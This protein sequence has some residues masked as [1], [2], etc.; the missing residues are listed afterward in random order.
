MVVVAVDTRYVTLSLENH[1][2]GILEADR[3]PSG[4]DYLEKIIQLPYRLPPVDKQAAMHKFIGAQLGKSEDTL[5]AHAEELK[6]EVKAE[7]SKQ[8]SQKRRQK[9]RQRR[10]VGT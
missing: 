9:R 2:K 5:A 7:K 6:G 1:Y 4:L 3:N 10:G 8:K